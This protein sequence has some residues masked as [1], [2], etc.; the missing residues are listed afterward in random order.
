M[1]NNNVALPAAEF[2]LPHWTDRYLQLVTSLEETLGV[3]R[4]PNV[5]LEHIMAESARKSQGH[6]IWLP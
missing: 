3:E 6:T 1:T 4:G 5:R 2:D